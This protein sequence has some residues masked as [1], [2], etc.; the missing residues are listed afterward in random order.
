MKKKLIL[1]ISTILVVVTLSI[2]IICLSIPK[3]SDGDKNPSPQTTS[4]TTAHTHIYGEWILQ[5]EAT[6][7]YAG[8]QYRVCECGE[9]DEFSLAI[10]EHYLSK[11]VVV[12]EAK[13]GLQGIEERLCANCN[14]KETQAINA[15][16]HTEGAWIIQNN[17]KEYL[18]IHCQ[19]LLRT[20]EINISQ[21]LEIVDD[22]VVSVGI[23]TELDVVVPNTNNNISITTIGEQAFEY[24][25]ITSIVL[26]DSIT[27]IEE[28]AF[29]QCSKLNTIHMGA[30]ITTIGKK[31]FFKCSSLESITLP[32]SLTTI[33][34]SAFAYCTSLKT[35]YMGKSITKLEMR[36]F[37]DCTELTD[38]YFDGTI[39]E[40][41][42]I[43]KDAEWDLGTSEYTV[44][45]I[46]GN[47]NK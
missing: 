14:Y 8:I 15:L 1:I 27:T 25:N 5:K 31:A 13:C 24:E 26:F 19:E 6:C 11:W 46:D 10:L 23:C 9:R 35:I 37:Q 30:N 3:N 32:D 4:T 45:C 28:N 12:E 38:I 2:L 47:I 40:W 22:K 7:S 18:C 33:K 39:E 29:Y 20:E 21:G 36:I 43:P 16:I 41:N 42:A 44:H 34:A 17:R